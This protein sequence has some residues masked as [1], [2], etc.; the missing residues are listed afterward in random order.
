MAVATG[1]KVKIDGDKR[2]SRGIFSRE[3]PIAIRGFRIFNLGKNKVGRSA[4]TE[5][6]CLNFEDC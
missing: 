6:P 2:G 3:A 5:R 1:K 4:R